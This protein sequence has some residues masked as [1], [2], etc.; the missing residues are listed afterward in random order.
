M[1]SAIVVVKEKRDENDKRWQ[2]LATATAPHIAKGA[3]SE[4]AENVWQVEFYR[5]PAALASLLYICGTQNLPYRL[6]AFDHPHQWL[7]FR[8]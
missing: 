5:S 3:I 1:H 4:V 2:I 8:G 6:L 7:Q